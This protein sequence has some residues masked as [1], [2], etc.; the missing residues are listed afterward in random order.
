MNKNNLINEINTI[1]CDERV[2]AF[3]N[4]YDRLLR[5]RQYNKKQN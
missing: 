5:C 1:K 2:G 4:E 3:S